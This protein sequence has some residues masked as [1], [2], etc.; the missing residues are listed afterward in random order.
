MISKNQEP[1][2]KFFAKNKPVELTYY[3]AGLLIQY[4]QKYQ[5]KKV[6]KF[7]VLKVETANSTMSGSQSFRGSFK[8]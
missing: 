1:S 4:P 7:R 5:A 6:M 8:I 3:K 2:Y